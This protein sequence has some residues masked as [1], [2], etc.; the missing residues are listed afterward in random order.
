MAS[1]V[2][3]YFP[4]R[5]QVIYGVINHLSVAPGGEKTGL[6]YYKTNLSVCNSA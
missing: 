3:V 6:K 5:T 1:R 2:C 4:Q